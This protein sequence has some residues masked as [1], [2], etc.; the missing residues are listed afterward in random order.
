MRFPQAEINFSDQSGSGRISVTDEASVM[1]TLIDKT[2]RGNP[3]ASASQIVWLGEREVT[4]L[5]DALDA[6][7]CRHDPPPADPDPTPTR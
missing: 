6:W 5:R 3:H 4:R 2:N 7:L 1:K